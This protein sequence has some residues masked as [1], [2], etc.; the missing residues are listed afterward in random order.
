MGKNLVVKFLSKISVYSNFITIEGIRSKNLGFGTPIFSFRDFY[1]NS[2]M[3]YFCEN[4][5]KI[6]HFLNVNLNK[7]QTQEMMLRL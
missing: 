2:Y 3:S 1:F 4:Y 7:M 6:A 5:I